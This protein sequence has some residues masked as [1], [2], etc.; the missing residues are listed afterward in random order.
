MKTECMSDG[1]KELMENKMRVMDKISKWG[2]KWYFRAETMGK[3]M[4]MKE[5]VLIIYVDGGAKQ[6][7]AEDVIGPALPH[8]GLGEM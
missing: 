8:L 7:Q 1:D 6:L 4:E 3:M 5:V 2:D